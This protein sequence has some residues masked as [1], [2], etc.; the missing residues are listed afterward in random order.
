LSPAGHGSLVAAQISE[1]FKVMDWIKRKR[2]VATTFT[3][4]TNSSLVYQALHYVAPVFRIS[5][6]T[7]YIMEAIIVS[8]GLF[9]PAGYDLFWASSTLDLRLAILRICLASNSGCQSGDRIGRQGSANG[10]FG[11]SI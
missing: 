4:F 6:D 8:S 2:V 11:R 3:T 1:Q 9:C 10:Q 7:I 5:G